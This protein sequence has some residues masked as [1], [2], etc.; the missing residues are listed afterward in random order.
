MHSYIRIWVHIVWSTYKRERI[1]HKELRP[2]LFRHLVDYAN[3]LSITT[4]RMNIQPE[5]VHSLI[6]LP[7]DKTLASIVK[8]LKG[9]STR[10][11]N[12]QRLIGGKFRWQRGYGAFSVSASQLKVV[13][14]Y[15]ESQDNH[16]K[17]RTFHDEYEEW[18]R[19]YGIFDPK[20]SISPR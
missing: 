7:T 17:R 2:K 14:H 3:E 6:A 18:I 19:K 1:L 12:Q 9:E 16:H 15:I 11:I 20:S 13:K 5:H 8:R 10:W 4:E